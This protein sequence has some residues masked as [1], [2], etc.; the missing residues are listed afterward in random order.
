MLLIQNGMLYTMEADTPIRADLL[1]KDGKIEKIAP[2]ISLTKEMRVLDAA[3]KG[4]YPGFID[5]HSHIGI[6]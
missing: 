6:A 3:G 4:V 2:K 5:A 1:I